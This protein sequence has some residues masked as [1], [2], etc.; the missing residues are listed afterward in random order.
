M[1]Q[2]YRRYCRITAGVFV[3]IT[4]YTVASKLAGGR[5]GEDWLYSVLHLGSALLGAAAGWYRA[6]SVPAKLFTWGIGLLYGVLGV[7]G[8]FTASARRARLGA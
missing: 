8:W 6:S 2:V 3:L 5:L 1:P 4:L 7:S